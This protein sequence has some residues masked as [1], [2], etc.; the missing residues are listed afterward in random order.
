MAVDFISPSQNFNYYSHSEI[1]TVA[2]QSDS[3]FKNTPNDDPNR[4]VASL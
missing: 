2:A 3:E 4:K 1:T